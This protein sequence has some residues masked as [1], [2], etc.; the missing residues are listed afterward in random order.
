[1][2]VILTLRATCKEALTFDLSSVQQEM[3]SILAGTNDAPLKGHNKNDDDDNQGE[4]C[5]ELPLSTND[6]EDNGDT[7]EGIYYID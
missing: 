2:W 5:I 3:D 7:L 6:D 4:K 1:M